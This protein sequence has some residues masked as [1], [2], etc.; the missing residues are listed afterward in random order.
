ML[1]EFQWATKFDIRNLRTYLQLY[2]D[3]AADQFERFATLKAHVIEHVE[4][5]FR[6]SCDKATKAINTM[7]SMEQWIF[8]SDPIYQSILNDLGETTSSEPGR[9]VCIV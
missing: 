1:T 7:M 3:L 9:N 5:L 6:Q 8:T 4:S 2:L